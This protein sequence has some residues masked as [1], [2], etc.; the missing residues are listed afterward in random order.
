MTRKHF[1]LI[2]QTFAYTRPEKLGAR[3][4]QWTTDVEA[5][6]YTLSTTNPRF[7]RERFFTACGA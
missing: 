7:D 1:I 6:A 3:R 4:E 5:M 2:A